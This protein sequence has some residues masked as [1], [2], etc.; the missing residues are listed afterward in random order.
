MS[1]T[2]GF[3]LLSTFTFAS[4][5]LPLALLITQSIRLTT[6]FSTRP[7]Q[8]NWTTSTRKS[9]LQNHL[10]CENTRTGPVDT[11]PPVVGTLLPVS[12]SVDTVLHPQVPDKGAQ[13]EAIGGCSTASR[14]LFWM[15]SGY[16]A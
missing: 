12:P 5:L 11:W 7:N 4:P 9:E 2:F 3:S 16:S 10:A 14:R 8:N 1:F 6:L 13:A 15:L